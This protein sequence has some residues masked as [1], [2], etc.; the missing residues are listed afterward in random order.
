M[1]NLI[2]NCQT[3]FQR[4]YTILYS[5]WKCKIIPVVPHFHKHLVLSVFLMLSI[6]PSVSYY[7]EYVCFLVIGIF[8]SVK[9]PIKFFCLFILIALFVFY[10]EFVFFN[11]LD[12]NPLSEICIANIF[13]RQWLAFFIMVS[14]D[15][16]NGIFLFS[17]FT[18]L[19][20]LCIQ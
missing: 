8:S 15:H 9:H 18:V 12:T 20:N 7:T 19:R 6:I 4:G 3:V 14:C 1:L 11:V 10:W 13:S 2:R 16:F 5:H 17:A